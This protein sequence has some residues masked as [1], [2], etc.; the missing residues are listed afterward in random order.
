MAVTA[1]GYV[2][3]ARRLKFEEK[4]KHAFAEFARD[5]PVPGAASSKKK[6]GGAAEETMNLGELVA[7][8]K[9]AQVLDDKC[10]VREV[11]RAVCNGMKRHETA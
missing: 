3:V 6:A 11:P 10:T 1:C 9:E 8:L 2:A 5:A 4:L 7:M